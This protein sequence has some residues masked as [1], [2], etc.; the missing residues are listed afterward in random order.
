MPIRA[1]LILTLVALPACTGLEPAVIGAAATGAQTA[2]GVFQRGKLDAADA[3]PLP[4]VVQATDRAL[5]EL[6]L[7]VV[8]REHDEQGLEVEARDEQNAWVV[9][10]LQRRTGVLTRIRID[11]GWFGSEPTARLVLSRIIGARGPNPDPDANPAPP[12]TRP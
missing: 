3:R 5:R 11:V 2:V 9:V 4:E 12:A 7:R 8:R 10:K 1:L 6:E